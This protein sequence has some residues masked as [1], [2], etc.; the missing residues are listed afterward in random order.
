[1]LRQQQQSPPQ[2]VKLIHMLRH[3]EGTHNVNEAYNDIINLDARL[4][5]HGQ[6]QCAKFAQA[7]KA[8]HF[9][10]LMKKQQEAQQQN[11][12]TIATATTPSQDICVLTS[13]MTRCIQTALLCFPWWAATT[14]SSETATDNRDVHNHSSVRVPFVAHEGIR[15]TVNFHCDRRRTRTEIATEFPQVDFSFVVDNHDPIWESYQ[16]R[17]LAGPDQHYGGARESAELYVVA[18]RAHIFLEWMMSTRA[19]PQIVICTHSAFLRAILNWGQAA[20][21]P[22]QMEQT[23]DDR[24]HSKDTTAAAA[25]SPIFEYCGSNEFREYMT[26]DYANCEMRSFCLVK[27]PPHQP[28]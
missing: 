25:E 4:T 16:Q 8:N 3:A 6:D 21:V 11:E 24:H 13:S 1:M 20:G 9:S 17:R 12:H 26:S 19:E 27:Q 7:A 2:N 5:R 28:L 14:T 23:L 22:K 18:E 15:E 10:D